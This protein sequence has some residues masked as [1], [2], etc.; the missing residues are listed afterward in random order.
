MLR[1]PSIPPKDLWQLDFS[2]YV[3]VLLDTPPEPIQD[4]LHKVKQPI[5]RD[6]TRPKKNLN[7]MATLQDTAIEQPVPIPWPIKLRKN[8]SRRV[9]ICFSSLFCPTIRTRYSGQ[10]W[11]I[12]R[13]HF[14]LFLRPS[15]GDP[16]LWSLLYASHYCI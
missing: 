11:T 9:S 10:W 3:A 1:C 12:V 2:L 7:T 8:Y 14:F 6:T 5:P 4:Y 13:I 15:L 16:R